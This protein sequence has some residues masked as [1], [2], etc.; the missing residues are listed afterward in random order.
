M[1]LSPT[2]RAVVAAFVVSGTTHLVRPEVFEPLMP[3]WVPAHRRVIVA[4]GVAELACAV[5]LVVPATRRIAAYASAALLVAVFPGNVEMARRASGRDA[6][7][8]ALAY[9]RL[10]LQVPM[11]VSMLRAARRSR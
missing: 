6:T 5:G 4:S 11:V 7:H 2:A 9:A 3:R 8:R 10:P 1:P